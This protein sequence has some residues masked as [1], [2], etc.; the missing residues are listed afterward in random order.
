MLKFD[1]LLLPLLGGYVFLITFKL[2]KF[3]HQRIER[4]RLIFNSLILAFFVSMI[5][6]LFDEYLLKSFYLIDYRAF[7]SKL[8]PIKYS[9]LNHSILIFFI[10]YPLAKLL[11]LIISDRYMLNYVVNKWGDEYEKLFWTSLQNKNDEDKLL[12]ITTKTN[13]VYVGFVN[14]I[15]EPIGDS[16]I[17]VIPNF[18]GYRNK[19]TQE[20]IFTTDYISVLKYLIESNQE[21]LIDEKMG[22]LIPKTEI[23]LVSR[24]DYNVFNR[25]NSV[26]EVENT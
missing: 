10:S 15:S 26:E 14:R 20:F 2:T 3:Y 25:F 7:F 21:N 11:N 17:T 6:L 22:V 19:D 13:K 4:Q 12:M 24:F 8:Q 16:H 18:S 1:L 9:G 23:I 5:G